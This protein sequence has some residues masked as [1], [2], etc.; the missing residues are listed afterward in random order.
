MVIMAVVQEKSLLILLHV[1]VE[2]GN[3]TMADVSL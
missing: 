3:V 1:L 2:N